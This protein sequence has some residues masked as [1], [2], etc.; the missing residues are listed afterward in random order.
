MYNTVSTIQYRTV[1]YRPYRDISPHKNGEHT[2]EQ[3]LNN[4]VQIPL[5]H[6]DIQYHVF[7]YCNYCTVI[8]YLVSERCNGAGLVHLIPRARTHT[9][10]HTHTH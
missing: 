5:Q 6:V 2:S 7:C 3:T 1:Q 9:H 10:T 4:T 8:I